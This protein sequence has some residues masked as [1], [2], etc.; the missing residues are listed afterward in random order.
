MF[1]VRWPGVPTLILRVREIRE[2]IG[3]SQA[4]LS[5][6][7]GVTAAAISNIE[8]GQVTGVEFETLT[9]LAGALKVDVALFFTGQT[10]ASK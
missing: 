10:P 3:W 1:G 6:E 4:K 2:A 8:T 9:K 5:R 7:S